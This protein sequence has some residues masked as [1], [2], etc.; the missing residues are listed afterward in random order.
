MSYQLLVLTCFDPLT[1]YPKDHP[2]H[3][4]YLGYLCEFFD[5][6]NDQTARVLMPSNWVFFSRLPWS[7]LSLLAFSW[8]GDVVCQKTQR[9]CPTEAGPWADSSSEFHEK[10]TC[11]HDDD[12][13]VGF[14]GLHSMICWSLNTWKTQIMGWLQLNL[15]WYAL[16]SRVIAR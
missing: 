16:N 3:L 7:L 4:R 2:R 9:A 12:F 11:R 15:P 14:A 8:L 6:N 10:K 5:R 1:P 13:I